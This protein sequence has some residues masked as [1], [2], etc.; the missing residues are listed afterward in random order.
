MSD[1]DLTDLFLLNKYLFQRNQITKNLKIEPAI[2]Y[3][4]DPLQS[5]KASLQS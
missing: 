3:E 2:V 1:V 4:I 5:I